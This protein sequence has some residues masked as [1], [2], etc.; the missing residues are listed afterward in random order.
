MSY[1]NILIWEIYKLWLFSVLVLIF[2]QVVTS[3]IYILMA[4][5][6]SVHN[7]Y[8][9]TFSSNGSALNYSQ[10][11]F[12]TK[13]NKC[14]FLFSLALPLNGNSPM[15]LNSEAKRENTEHTLS[16]NCVKK[17]WPS[18]HQTTLQPTISPG[19]CGHF[20]TTPITPPSLVS[21]RHKWGR[22]LM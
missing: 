5:H 12:S 22:V 2:H 11:S 18:Q 8:S 10:K 17:G 1:L 15:T 4:D 21:P 6:N 9:R 19:L 7:N 20:S 16:S 3:F 13:V 14:R